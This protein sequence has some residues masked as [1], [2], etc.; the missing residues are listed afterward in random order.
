MESPLTRITAC[1]SSRCEA[2][3]L[4]AASVP[5]AHAFYKTG[6]DKAV[7]RMNAEHTANG[8]RIRSFVP[9]ITYSSP[10]AAT[11]DSGG[12][13]GNNKRSSNPVEAA[14]QSA[15]FPSISRAI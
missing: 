6:T 12:R 13:D 10:N 14:Q 8:A 1:A 11:T 4:A 5:E 15:R 3:L 2:M 7:S 9:Q